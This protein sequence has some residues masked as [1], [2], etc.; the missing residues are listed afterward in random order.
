MTGQP[1]L[2]TGSVVR[3]RE[4]AR[5]LHMP[6]HL[7]SGYDGMTGV[8]SLFD[9]EVG[10][11]SVALEGHAGRV[12]RIEDLEVIGEPYPFCVGDWV[13]L[14]ESGSASD[15]L[16]VMQVL[17]VFQGD[18]GE[19][20]LRTLCIDGVQREWPACLFRPAKSDELFAEK[21]RLMDL[22]YQMTLFAF[23]KI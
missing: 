1:K 14:L 10:N 2:E 6:H 23:S 15:P 21:N 13:K 8:A 19:R 9:K 20:Y 7:S 11:A 3:V 5:A 17:E 12:F 16:E 4:N 22:S 18:N